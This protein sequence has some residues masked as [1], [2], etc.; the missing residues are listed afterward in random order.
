MIGDFKLKKKGD[1]FCITEKTTLETGNLVQQG[2]PYYSG[3]VSYHAEVDVNEQYNGSKLV[4][5]GFD[6]VV[7]LVKINGQH[8][9]TLGWEPY[10]IN[11][12]PYLKRGSNDI[13]IEIANSL[14]IC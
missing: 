1:T 12:G 9:S 10:V 7:A 14:Q 13:T 3:V 11:I 2:Y 5:D 8:V 4:F 6:G